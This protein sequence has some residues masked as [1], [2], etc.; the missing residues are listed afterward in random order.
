M[1]NIRVFTQNTQFPNANNEILQ[2]RNVFKE[3]SVY[4]HLLY[5]TTIHSLSKFSKD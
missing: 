5:L 1:K 4:L 2:S 3:N